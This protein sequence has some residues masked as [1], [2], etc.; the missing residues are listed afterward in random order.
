MDQGARYNNSFLLEKKRKDSA[1]TSDDTASMIEPGTATLPLINDPLICHDES[2]YQ[3]KHG[4]Q[5]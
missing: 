2:W 3:L 4:L 5:V 1:G